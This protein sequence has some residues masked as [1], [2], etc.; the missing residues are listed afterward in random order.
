ME[1][2]KTPFQGE[3]MLCDLCKMTQQ[4]DPVIES[5]WYQIVIDGT[6]RHICPRCFGNTATPQCGVCQRFYHEDLD[7]C[8]WH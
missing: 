8:P 2:P 6:P 1:T 5:G 4:S 3:L 7:R